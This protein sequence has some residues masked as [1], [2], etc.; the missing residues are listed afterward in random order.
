[1]TAVLYSRFSRSFFK[2]D[3]STL[4]G[5]LDCPFNA[6]RLTSSSTYVYDSELV[7]LN[8]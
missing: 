8:F 6:P 1:M 4:T 3:A 7:S 5:Y 2:I